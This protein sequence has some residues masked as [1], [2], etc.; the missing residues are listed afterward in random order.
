MAYMVVSSPLFLALAGFA[1]TLVMVVLVLM[2]VVLLVAAKAA[3]SLITKGK[4]SS[5]DLSQGLPG[6]GI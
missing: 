2:V 1:A 5:F 3:A 6:G 4:R